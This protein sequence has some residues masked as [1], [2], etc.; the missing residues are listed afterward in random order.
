[1]PAVDIPLTRRLIV[2]GGATVAVFASWQVA[3][4][5]FAFTGFAVAMI[6][7]LVANRVL[8]ISPD[9]ITAG[10]VLV[11]YLVGNRGFAQ[12]SVP[13][14]PLLPGELALALGL[15]CTLW[16]A[17]RD[18]RLPLRRD[19]LNFVVLLWLALGAARLP[20]DV[21]SHGFV[22]IRDFAMVYY[23][24]F[25]FLAQEWAREPRSRAWIGGCLTVG[26]ALT[27]PAFTAFVLRTDFFAHTLVLGNAPL[28]Y[29]KSDVAGSF[30]AAGVFWFLYRYTER[31]RPL[32]LGLVALNLGGVF[33]CNNRAAVVA[34]LFC[35]AWVVVLHVKPWLRV[36]GALAAVGALALLGEAALP[37]A[38]GRSSQAY[39]LYESALTV[40][41]F[42]GSHVPLTEDLSDKPD[43]N[44]FRT[45]WWREVIGEA[46]SEGLWFGLG[47]GHDLTAQ[48]V[49]VY[50]AESGE[51][52]TVRS[53]HNFALSVFARMGL[54]GSGLLLMLL[55]LTA[56]GTW[57]SSLQDE[58]RRPH[59]E[60]LA[61]WAIFVSACLGVVLEGPMGAVVFWTSLG[62]AN[63]EL[64]EPEIPAEA[65]PREPAPLPSPAA[66]A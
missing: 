6:L 36:L 39:R 8:R 22:A 13:N 46:S 55:G 24:L 45:T 12:L 19:A 15:V 63:S 62:L 2:V 44:R 4:G 49:Q 57:R 11:G 20:I 23:A 32:W 37:H 28:I 61:V 64:A 35:V 27:M 58:A 30:M 14:L 65:S 38:S 3:H 29:V 17:A 41:D 7:L 18:Q 52:F 47:F 9:V 31:R 59:P 48:F 10:A 66:S 50:Y 33:W 5:S 51:D 60:W 43:N 40:V 54:A 21:R 16:R 53:P 25:F 1:M 34:L 56:R 42:S 26:L